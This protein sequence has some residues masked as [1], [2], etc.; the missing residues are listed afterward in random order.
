MVRHAVDEVEQRQQRR[1]GEEKSKAIFPPQNCGSR[2]KVTSVKP[3]DSPDPPV[4]AKHVIAVHGGGRRSRGGRRGWRRR[5]L[6]PTRGTRR[7]RWWRWR[8]RFRGRQ[9]GPRQGSWVRGR[10]RSVDPRRRR[11]QGVLCAGPAAPLGGHGHRLVRGARLCLGGREEERKEP[12][13]EEG[14]G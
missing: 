14:S 8:R 5:R 4:S 1:K 11:D 10:R 7:R 12:E 3:P 9:R 2:W 6:I 13:K